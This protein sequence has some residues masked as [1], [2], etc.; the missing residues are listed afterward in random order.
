M[1]AGSAGRRHQH[2]HRLFSE[3]P[4][5]VD[6]A[7]GATIIDVDGRSFIDLMGSYGPNLLGHRH[8][9]VDREVERQRA[10]GDSVGG[11]APVA[12]ELAEHLCSGS[13]PSTGS[14]SGRTAPTRRA[15]PSAWPGWRRATARVLI[16]EASYHT[17]HDWGTIFEAGVPAPHRSLTSH[18]AYN[19]D[20]SLRAAVE[21]ADG[22]LAAIMINPF[23]QG[24]FETPSIPTASF[25]ETIRTEARRAG[26][27]VI[28]DDVRANMRMHPS[29]SSSA[30]IGLDPDLLCFGKA[31]AN[32]RA[33]SVCAGSAELREAADQVG[34]L[35]TFFASAMA[36]SAGLATFQAFDIEGS[37]ERMSAGRPP[38]LDGPRRGRIGRRRAHR[39]D[40]GPRD[41]HG[42]HRGRR[43]G[44]LPQPRLVHGDG[45]ARRARAPPPGLVPVR[46]PHRRAGRRRSRPGRGRLRRGRCGDRQ[47]HPRPVGA[48]LRNHPHPFR[49]GVVV[50]RLHDARS[51][52]RLCREVEALG[53]ASLYVPDSSSPQMGPV[54]ALATAA[55]HT[56]TLRI[57]MLVAN[58]DLRNPAVLAKELATLDVLSDGRLEWGMERAGTRP[59]TGRSA[60]PWTVR[61]CGWRA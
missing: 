25:V 44:P 28:L 10:R 24:Y 18:F 36:Q 34:Y 15:T 22:D 32:G 19:D 61:R 1:I 58:N 56:T 33:L 16:A 53:Y 57:G 40:G 55:A 51:W 23:H 12:I 13:I 42:H 21:A 6:R 50:A 49:F 46:R 4:W 52:R 5:Y 26:A 38:T 14:S 43:L 7:E 9:I 11:H 29:G 17:A 3:Y 47:P 37:F 54:A 20:D 45:A 60:C 30:A 31:V 48:T 41:V 35:G 2:L 59:T 8:P 39:G 27:V